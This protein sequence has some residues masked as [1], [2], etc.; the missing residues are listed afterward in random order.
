[1]LSKSSVSKNTV[2]PIVDVPTPVFEEAQDYEATASAESF[3]SVKSGNELKL[4]HNKLRRIVDR[5]TLQEIKDCMFIYAKTLEIIDTKFPSMGN[6]KFD[7][8]LANSL[9]PEWFEDGLTKR[10]QN[11]MLVSALLLT[12]TSVIFIDPPITGSNTDS[13]FRSLIY[14]SGVCNMCF[15]L[16]ILFAVFFIENAMSRAYGKSERL[17]LIIEYYKYKNYS[18]YFMVLGTLLFP[19]VLAIP[20]WQS[21]CP[22]D[23]HILGII[24][25]CCIIV[26]GSVISH[27]TMA[28]AAEQQRRSRLFQ[29]LVDRETCRILPQYFPDDVDIYWASKR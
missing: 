15:I 13:D 19:A 1:M 27:T 24:T 6:D 8:A 7:W 18:Q 9:S 3:W 17:C 5:T 26:I 20:M 10:L 25:L 23:A 28:A 12:V 29:S 2:H 11:T 21:F 22:V 14:L 4:F 16:S